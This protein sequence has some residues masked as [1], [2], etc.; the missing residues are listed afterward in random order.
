M[1]RWWPGAQ[2]CCWNAEHSPRSRFCPAKLWVNCWPFLVVCQHLV[3]RYR[4]ACISCWLCAINWPFLGNLGKL[5]AS[6]FL[7]TL[8][9]GR[10]KQKL[11]TPWIVRIDTWSLG[12]FSSFII[13]GT[14]FHCF[15]LH[16]WNSTKC[17]FPLFIV[18]SSFQL[19][20]STV[21]FPPFAAATFHLS[22]RRHF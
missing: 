22:C 10:W 6:W 18:E 2:A 20:F 8:Q 7:A 11:H 13:V 15:G 17:F 12:S 14:D 19:P 9:K 3:V 5:W 16:N 21:Y 1:H 4:C